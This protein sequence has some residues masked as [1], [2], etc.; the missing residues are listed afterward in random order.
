[1]RTSLPSLLCV[2]RLTAAALRVESG[3]D[4]GAELGRAGRA[5]VLPVDVLDTAR[6]FAGVTGVNID[7]AR[8]VKVPRE[9]R[10]EFD[11]RIPE[12]LQAGPEVYADNDLDRG[13]LARRADLLWGPKAEA[14]RANKDSFF[15]TN[16]TPQMDDFNQSTKEGLWG[17]L[18][19]AV[20]ADVDVDDLK[21]SVYGGPVFNADD[22]VFRGVAIPREFYKAIAFVV[23]GELRCSAFLLTQNLVLA[24]ALD[25]DEFRV[26]QV[27]LSELEKRVSLTFPAELHAADTA[28]VQLL[29]E[30]E[31]KPL[32][33]LADIRW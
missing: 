15:F 29:D 30:S 3:G 18:E 5:G 31:R 14:Q 13:H 1:M 4:P 16:I 10:W 28:S 25:L 7:G 32:G 33:S 8:L 24:E 20:L 26:F 27:S 2:Q 12:E 19:E 23:N 11:D 9:D 21:V 17:R 6:R 22:R